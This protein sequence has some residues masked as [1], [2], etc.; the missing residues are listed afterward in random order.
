[1]V[2]TR[3]W[4]ARGY[5]RKYKCRWQCTTRIHWM[6]NTNKITNSHKLPLL[7]IVDL[8]IPLV[9]SNFSYINCLTC[10]LFYLII[11]TFL[12]HSVLSVGVCGSLL[13]YLYLPSSVSLLCTAICIYIFF[14]SP[15]LTIDVLAQT[16]IYNI[17]YIDQQREIPQAWH[18]IFCGFDMGTNWFVDI[19]EI[20]V[21]HCLNFL[22][23]NWDAYR[24]SDNRQ[25]YEA[26]QDRKKWWKCMELYKKKY[27][28]V[29]KRRD[30]SL[31]IYVVYIVN[32]GLCFC[33]FL[34]AIVDLIIPLVSS[35]FGLPK[36][37]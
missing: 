31:L 24:Y 22:L 18:T 28:D 15:S 26:K 35:N 12:S 21:H 3:Q 29:S 30:F 36:K 17:H 10:K 27:Y 7:A 32:H 19:S 11:L 34:L 2:I 20:V 14:G 23:S 9:S 37:I 4:L 16:M 1:M 8:I 33:P 6:V 25:G 13:F 5:Q